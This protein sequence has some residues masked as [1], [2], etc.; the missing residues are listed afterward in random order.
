MGTAS[1]K[2]F[3]SGVFGDIQKFISPEQS[4]EDKLRREK[5]KQ[6]SAL[7]SQRIRL[8]KSRGGSLLDQVNK[9]STLG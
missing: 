1:G 3:S 7:E 9:T 8:L 6:T 2:T 5:E 4:L